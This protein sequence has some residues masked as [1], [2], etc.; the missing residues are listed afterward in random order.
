MFEIRKACLRVTHFGIVWQGLLQCECNVRGEGDTI[1]PQ[2]FS[3]APSR[4]PTPLPSHLAP[5]AVEALVSW[6]PKRVRDSE[7]FPRMAWRTVGAAL[8]VRHPTASH[9]RR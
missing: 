5:L 4:S 1:Q 3:P 8:C 9:G 7:N 2:V 6:N